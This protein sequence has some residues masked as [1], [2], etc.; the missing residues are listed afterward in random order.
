[1][2]L[3]RSKMNQKIKLLTAGI[4]TCVI[5]LSVNFGAP[6]KRPTVPLITEKQWVDSVFN[7]MTLDQ[8]IGQFFM[9][10]TFSN[11]NEAYYRSTD[12]LIEQY[13]IGG[14]IFFQGGPVRQ[15]ALT[16]R[17]Q[18]LSKT[19][20]FVGIDGE[21]GLGMRLDSV[22]DFPKQMTL[23]AIQD[24]N[25]I[26]QMGAE[27]ARH[28]QRIGI[29]INFA[30]VADINSNPRNPVIGLRSF[31]ENRDNVTDK[32]GAFMKGLQRN[33]IIATA[34]HFPGHGDT[35]SDS[36]YTLPVVSHSTDELDQTDLYPFQKLI[37][38]SLT[39]I[40][41]GH[42]HVPV[43]DNTPMLAA[44]L[45]DKIVTEL[46]KKKMGFKG[47]V[48]TD[49]LNMR[50]VSRGRTAPEVNLKALMA[51]NDILLYP[52]SVAESVKK[53]KEAI[54]KGTLPQE[55]V[56]EKVQKILRAKFWT[57]LHQYK[58]I[59]LEQISPD[60]R[61]ERLKTLLRNLAEKVVT[62]VHNDQNLLPIATLDTCQF[63]SVALGAGYDNAFQK[64]LS[65]CADFKHFT[66]P[67]QLTSAQEVEEIVAQLGK[68]NTIVVS[69]HDTRRSF[70]R[71][72]NLP[73]ATVSLIAQLQQKAKVVV[74][75]FGSPY[76][77]GQIPPRGAVV[78]AYEDTPDLQIVAAQQIFGS[79]PFVGKLPVSIDELY[80][81]GTGIV[82]K[83]LDRLVFG[84]PEQVGLSAV[85]LAQVD[86]LVQR[87]IK[88][89][90]FPGC[91]IAVAR[92]GRLVYQKNFGTLTYD[93]PTEKVTNETIYD[94]ASVTKV[95]ATLQ[96]IML[97]YERGAIDIKQKA[98]HYLPELNRTN[99][100]NCSI[101]DL[102]L[103]RAG[104][105]AFYPTLWERTQTGG[106]GLK[107]EYYSSVRDSVFAMQVAPKLFA[108]QALRDSVWKWVVRSPL[109][110]RRGQ[111]ASYPFIYSDLGILLLQKVVERVANQPLNDFL[112][113]NFYEPLGM[114]LTGFCPLSYFLPSQ[115]APTENDYKFRNQLLR[116]TVHDQMAAIL[117]GVAGHAGL[118][119]CAQDLAVLM[120]MNLQKGSY[121]NRRYFQPQTVPFFARTYD[122]P[123]HRGLGWDK[124]PADGES[125]YVAE[126]ASEASFGHSG[127]T[128]TMVWADPAEELVFVLLSNRVNPRADNNEM[129]RQKIR[130]QVQEAVYEAII[131]TTK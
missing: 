51:G 91:Q 7:G 102:L 1:L 29:N 14:V 53:I 77:I 52:E 17:Y 89:R 23:G 30:P 28:C 65:R 15:A 43:L 56:D 59:Q 64:T 115:I 27:I 104:L 24:N 19:P 54:Q 79:L 2:Q 105:V 50:G 74:C 33:R 107:P 42:L 49:A 35:D 131:D 118:F 68:A 10:A 60:L 70:N 87:A 69:L 63:A 61:T 58:P 113:Q 88:N 25:L 39:G 125:N 37:A 106:G 46:L 129:N 84:L 108:K 96:A 45:S 32:A 71:A 121:G 116:G 119:S 80:P 31:G 47:L 82:T 3:L 12:L 16:N 4:L 93:A 130:K 126:S 26:V 72:F 123:N 122:E 75:L 76:S 81:I 48:F 127:F 99:K 22:P 101:E 55:V 44:S 100:A 6:T 41:T 109:T 112:K 36:H 66:Y 5:F 8:K 92:R 38:D 18:A 110:N 95:A 78:C 11:R 124:A 86:T 57:G 111:G 67:D 97:L 128:G 34:K 117:G 120:Q 94:V 13:H 9:V 85:K 40:I 83:P 98:A 20:L 21:W 103:H 62:L 73:S 90:V 114:G